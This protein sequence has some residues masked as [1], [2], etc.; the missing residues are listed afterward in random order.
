[1]NSQNENFVPANI[2][3]IE[4]SNG[5]VSELVMSL[6]DRN[7]LIHKKAIL[8]EY[9]KLIEKINIEWG[10]REPSELSVIKIWEIGNAILE[11]RTNIREKYG[12]DITNIIDAISKEINH[13]H[14]AIQYMVQFSVMLPKERIDEKISWGKYQE[15]IQLKKKEDF[16]ESLNK[17]IDEEL[18]TSRDVRKFVREKNKIISNIK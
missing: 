12:V 7:Y 11:N 1:M 5:L 18:K 13:S 15:A 8:E 9:N 2:I 3:K 16:E 10:D 14:R 17:I 6:K 4:T